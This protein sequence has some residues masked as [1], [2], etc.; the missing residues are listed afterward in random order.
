MQIKML[1]MGKDCVQ[2]YTVFWCKVYMWTRSCW[3]G[4]ICHGKEENDSADFSNDW[5]EF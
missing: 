1:L 5:L 4:L 2:M 3:Y